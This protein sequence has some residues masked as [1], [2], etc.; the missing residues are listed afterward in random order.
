MNG[1]G[2]DPRA[3]NPRTRPG[4]EMGARLTSTAIGMG[5]GR[6]AQPVAESLAKPPTGS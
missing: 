2:Q 1:K 5:G 4:R 6:G 3:R